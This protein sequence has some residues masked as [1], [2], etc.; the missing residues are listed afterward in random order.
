[1]L[2]KTVIG[3]LE[4]SFAYALYQNKNDET[5]LKSALEAIVPHA[6]GDHTLCSKTWCG[7][8]REPKTYKHTDLPNGEI[9]RERH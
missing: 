2:S 4:K 5:R 1:M 6:F 9:Y 3:Y 7:Y 8:H